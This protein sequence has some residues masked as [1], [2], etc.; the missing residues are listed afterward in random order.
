ME[1]LGFAP[2]DALPV[3]RGHRLV[4]L[5]EERR[6]RA[7]KALWYQGDPADG[8]CLLLEGSVRALMYRSDES[9]LEMGSYGPGSWLGVPE[10]A[11][12][13][14]RLLD[15]SVLSGVHALWFSRLAFERLLEE[16]GLG[17]WFFRDLARGYYAL[18]SRVELSR[19]FDRIARLLAAESGGRPARVERTQEEL[20][21]LVGASRETVN[22]NLARM[23][24]LG[25]VRV[26]RGWVEVL[27]P[28]G[29]EP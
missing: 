25:W 1:A 20:A 17:R 18:H 21:E 26:G 27:E 11:L 9:T 2:F 13:G 3:E 28:R 19:P 14:P 23:Q 29:L 8:C 16:P 4:G 5:G 22:R 6:L 7:G 12:Q 10:L 24:E 15:L